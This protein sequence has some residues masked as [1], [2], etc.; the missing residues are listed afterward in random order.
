MD[1]TKEELEANLATYEH[2]EHIRRLLRVFALKLLERGESHDRSKLGDFERKTFTEFT[3]KLRT[4]TYGSDEYKECLQQ[5]APALEHHYVCN[6][7]HPEFFADGI[8]GMNLLDLLEMFI[9]WKASTLRHEDGDMSRSIEINQA[10]FNMSSQ[11]R[12]IFENTQE[13]LERGDLG[14]NL[15][16]PLLG[17]PREAKKTPSI[18][19]LL[20]I[21]PHEP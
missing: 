20:G 5:M 17:V 6:R 4:T 3:P 11:L 8:D 7:H 16:E 13:D 10:R 19:R 1:L 2:L 12:K 21:D 15:K 9:D 18:Y 14:D